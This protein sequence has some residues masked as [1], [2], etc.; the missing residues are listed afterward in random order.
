MENE[1]TDR[2]KVE[3]LVVVEFEKE[4]T[5]DK[6]EA[7]VPRG[8]SHDP[9]CLSLSD[10]IV[11]GD[12]AH[13]ELENSIIELSCRKKTKSLKSASE[14]FSERTGVSSGE[15]KIPGVSSGEQE[16]PGVSSG[17]QRVQGVSSGEQRVPGV[18]SGEQRVP[19]V[20]W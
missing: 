1:N 17:E 2:P 9:F 20:F 5:S 4:R 18:S 10:K 11:N 3:N 15:Q 7:I 19:G 13:D 6:I 8:T 16:V 14:T 12:L